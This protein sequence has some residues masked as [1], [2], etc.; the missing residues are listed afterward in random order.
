MRFTYLY[1]VPDAPAPARPAPH[2]SRF[3]YAAQQ[4]RP[5]FSRAA[6]VP[7]QCVLALNGTYDTTAT[8]NSTTSCGWKYKFT[9]TGACV[10]APD[11]I[12]A[13]QTECLSSNTARYSCGANGT[14]VSDPTG[15]FGSPD[16]L[17]CYACIGGTCSA[18]AAGATTGTHKTLQECQN[19]AAAK[20]GWKYTCA[21]SAT[22]GDYADSF[23]P[24]T[25]TKYVPGYLSSYQ[26][27]NKADARCVNNTSGP[28]PTCTCAYTGVTGK[29]NTVTQCSTDATVQCGWKFGCTPPMTFYAFS[30]NFELSSKNPVTDL[31]TGIQHLPTYDAP[32]YLL[33]EMS[34]PFVAYGNTLTLTSTA[35]PNLG[36][37]IYLGDGGGSDILFGDIV[38]VGFGNYKAGA[39]DPNLGDRVV[40]AHGGRTVTQPFAIAGSSVQLTA[41]RN[42]EAKFPDPLTFTASVIPGYQYKVYARRLV[43]TDDKAGMA[44]PAMEIKVSNK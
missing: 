37:R 31:S 33:N 1:N 5:A 29:F 4:R 32:Q 14:V 11:G 44:W 28:G 27:A 21:T 3:Q 23:D 24:A 15:Y 20:C 17:K 10:L 43:Q 42:Q 34:D 18:V 8:C 38:V 6:F 35:Q 36:A 19:D 13:T 16:A 22:D 40:T 26:Y 39:I 41:G 12:Y 30:G 25:F 7:P 2:V 9:P